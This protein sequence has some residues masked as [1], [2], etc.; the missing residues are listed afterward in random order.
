MSR[1]RAG[2][3][4][5]RG[6]IETGDGWQNGRRELTREPCACVAG[7]TTLLVAQPPTGQW[8]SH[9]A[10]CVG[11]WFPGSSLGGIAWVGEFGRRRAG[12]GSRELV[13]SSASLFFPGRVR[14]LSEPAQ[15]QG[16]TFPQPS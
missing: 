7:L 5:G 16:L 13:L 8:T 14:C 12:S 1:E 10:C 6:T 15:R 2:P 9:P 11:I 3:Y 4:V